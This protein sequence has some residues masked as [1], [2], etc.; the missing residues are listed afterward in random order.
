MYEF[1]A[2]L[3]DAF[4]RYLDN[5]DDNAEQQ[6][7]DRINRVPF[8]SEAADRGTAFGLL[9]NHFKHHKVEPDN[10]GEVSI[11]HKGMI[12]AFRADVVQEF[13][14]E[15]GNCP[16]EVQVE[17][18]LETKYGEVLLYGYIDELVGDT[19]YDT[20]TTGNYIFPKYLKAWQHRVYLYCL[21][22]EGNKVSLFTYLVTDFNNVYK[23]TYTYKP[24]SDRMKLKLHCEG[25]IEFIEAKKNMISDAKIFGE[26]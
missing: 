12:Q 6:L 17:S 13:V 8:E 5:D 24:Y 22:N 20:K 1:Y 2:T 18:V 7:L 19:A 21:N 9:V 16:E 3:L 26:C 11:E 25:L 23:E 14:D 15:Y 10:N 4:Q